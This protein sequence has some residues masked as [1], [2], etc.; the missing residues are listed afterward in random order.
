MTLRGAIRLLKT[1]YRRYCATG[2][3][4]GHPLATLLFSQGLWASSIYRLAHWIEIERKEPVLRSILRGLF[5]VLHKVVEVLTGI[6]IPATTVVG[7]G[8]Y[9]GHFGHIIVSSTAIIGENCNLSQGVTIGAT[10]RGKYVGSPSLGNRVYVGPNALILGGI[11]VGDDAVIGGGSV[12]TIPVPERAVVV[13]NPAKVVSF[14]GSFELI[15]Y[16]DMEHDQMRAFSI[17]QRQTF[18]P[19]GDTS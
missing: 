11:T 10:Q 5:L 2:R 9:I 15:R 17:E 13:G 16:D 7:S 14:K 1:D 12:V 4:S 3:G 6:S 19:S 18:D 8:L